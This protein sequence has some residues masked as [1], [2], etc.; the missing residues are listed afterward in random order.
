LLF[1]VKLT[2]MRPTL[3]ALVAAF[4][5]L[6]ASCKE[7]EQPV[8]A[9]EALA[10]AKKI[11]SAVANKDLHFFATF[12]NEDAFARKVV[13]QGVEGSVKV[14][15]ESL[16]NGM[17]RADFG[18]EIIAETESGG[19]YVLFRHYE[20]DG[21]HRLLYRLY[22]GG[23]NYHDFEL[24][25][26]GGKVLVSDIY[27]YVSGENFSTSMANFISN[28]IR[29]G[30]DTRAATAMPA[31]AQLVHEGKYEEAKKKFDKLPEIV[32]D[33][34]LA[35]VYYLTI[36]AKLDEE[37]Y[38]KFLKKFELRFRHEP[39]MYLSLIDAYVFRKEFD[40]ALDAVNKIDSMVGKDPFLDYYRYIFYYNMNKMPEAK[41][42]LEKLYKAMPDFGQGVL[43]LIVTYITDKEYDKARQLVIA[44][45]ENDDFDQD[46]LEENLDRF[47]DFHIEN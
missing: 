46:A 16:K 14:I 40:R 47:P 3:T 15:R 19:K 7:K 1:W 45:R 33:Q 20:K 28:M 26:T 44:Y 29:D 34:K 18:R 4:V 32:K 12:L 8:T 22:G 39:S 36:S 5:L 9:Q 10:F 31:I 6:I 27:V 37:E 38:E 30:G 41:Q 2:S 35:Q 23:L 17:K 13:D 25:K 24:I 42:S 11:D 21:K 43:E